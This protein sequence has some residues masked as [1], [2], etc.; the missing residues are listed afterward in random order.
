MATT[1][2]FKIRTGPRERR[3]DETLT[4]LVN[5]V[6]KMHL[7]ASEREELQ[8]LYIVLDII[9]GHMEPLKRRL[10]TIKDGEKDAK[11]IVTKVTKLLGELYATVPDDQHKVLMRHINSTSYHMGVRGPAKDKQH[12]EF[13][14]WIPWNVL[15][16]LLDSC[17]D[18]C[19][20]CSLDPQAQQACALRKALDAIPSDT[21]DR[22][23]GCR[24]QGV[25]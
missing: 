11:I 8:R 13:G 22:P 21:P 4:A 24:Y 15:G 23:G 6:E 12:D 2:K 20:M 17:K 10:A 25:I 3:T 18:N 5:P 14:M 7:Y 16:T 9:S 19:L 1:T